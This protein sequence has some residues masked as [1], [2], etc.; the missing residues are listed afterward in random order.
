M[1][2]RELLIYLSTMT[3]LG[4]SYKILDYL[5]NPEVTTERQPLI[6]FGHGSPLNAIEDNQFSR[7]WKQIGQNLNPKA[8]LVISAHWETEGTRIHAGNK[9]PMIYDFAGFPQ[10]LYK[11]NYPAPSNPELAH[12]LTKSRLIQPDQWGLDHGAWSVLLHAFPKAQIPVIQLSLNKNL[13]PEEHFILAKELKVLRHQGVLIVGSGNIVHNL[14]LMDWKNQIKYLW[15]QQTQEQILKLI[16]NKEYE[17][18]YSITQTENFKLAHPTLEHYLPLLYIFALAD[19]DENVEVF[20]PQI[21]LSTISMA[22]F[23]IK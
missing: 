21:E 3:A 9:N 4:L 10:E 14:R 11:I 16:E 8:I 18:L 12:Q 2:R 20:T 7:S 19:K 23:L 22:S 15:A 5:N 1:K 6:F 17:K 13:S